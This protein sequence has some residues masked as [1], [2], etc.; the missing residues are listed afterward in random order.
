MCAALRVLDVAPWMERA[1]CEPRD[2]P[3]RGDPP[4]RSS[5]R[6]QHGRGAPLCQP[7][8]IRSKSATSAWPRM[9]SLAT[10]LA[11]SFVAGGLLFALRRGLA[12]GPLLL[13]TRKGPAEAL[14]GGYAGREQQEGTA[15]GNSRREQQ[16]G[17]AGENSRRGQ[18]EGS[19]GGSAGKVSRKGQQ[20]AAAGRSARV[21]W[22][23]DV[24]AET[25]RPVGQS[26]DSL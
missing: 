12:A 11:D 2:H 21:A 3:C 18:Q 26:S 16:E 15:G 8:S 25:F 24:P 6:P 22:H 9:G 20:G 5:V 17:T 13:V 14:P 23:I 19:A 4:R 7:I 1:R 10:G